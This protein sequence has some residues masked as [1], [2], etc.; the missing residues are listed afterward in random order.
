MKKTRITTYDPTL[1]V[2]ENAENNGVYVY[3]IRHYIKANHIDRRTDK[4]IRTYKLIKE[5]QKDNPKDK[6]HQI[7]LELNL[8]AN[9]VRKYL[10]MSEPPKEKTKKVSVMKTVEVMR[11]LSVSDN[12]HSILK[13][14]LALHLNNAKTFHCDL[15]AWTCGFYKKGIE[16]PPV[17]YDLFPQLPEV[18]K[19]EELIEDPLYGFGS[20]VIDLPTSISNPNSKREYNLATSFSTMDELQ[21][22]NKKMLELAYKILQ[23]DGIL[24]FKTMDFTY[25]DKPQWISNFVTITAEELG[26]ELIDKFIYID[27]KH[28]K[29]D[30]RRTRYSASVPSHAYFLVFRKP[31]KANRDL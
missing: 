20:I 18:R 9:T 13:A 29:I 28:N 24:V 27:P 3:T 1:S 16:R 8:T 12:Q 2:K 10:K 25:M 26:F 7:A 14:I 5:Y 21:R 19:L 11:F 6:V 17:L 30:R 22:E 23:T 4:L 31:Y 15:T